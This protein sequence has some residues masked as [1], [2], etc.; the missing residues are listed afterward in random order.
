MKRMTFKEIFDEDVKFQNENGTKPLMSK[1]TFDAIR[2]NFAYFTEEEKSKCIAFY[3]EFDRRSS[4]EARENGTPNDHRYLK[5]L[6]GTLNSYGKG[7]MIK[8][9][10]E[11]GLDYFYDCIANM[12]DNEAVRDY[13]EKLGLTNE[14]LVK[15]V[16]R[17]RSVESFD[18]ISTNEM[19]RR[20]KIALAMGITEEDIRKNPIL[21][22]IDSEILNAR[23]N[24]YEQFSGQAISM[25]YEGIKFLT[26]PDPSF[27]RSWGEKVRESAKAHDIKKYKKFFK[28]GKEYSEKDRII[29]TYA[30]IQE[31]HRD[32]EKEKEKEVMERFFEEGIAADEL[33]EKWDNIL[34][35]GKKA[36]PTAKKDEITIGL[37]GTA[38]TD[39]KKDEF[40]HR[41]TERFGN[42][43]K[44]TGM[45]FSQQGK[46]KKV[47]KYLVIDVGAYTVLEPVGQPGNATY[48]IASEFK[49]FLP[50]LTRDGAKEMGVAFPINHE[51]NLG[52]YNWGS[53]KLFKIIDALE[54]HQSKEGKG[55]TREEHFKA[56][57]RAEAAGKIVRERF[58]DSH[59]L[60][61]AMKLGVLEQEKSTFKEIEMFVK[62]RVGSK[63]NNDGGEI[64]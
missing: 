43:A 29:R 16:Y 49:E 36:G 46:S 13:F 8:H 41:M 54:A 34:P 3:F 11:F 37:S 55:F 31:M 23:K 62:K 17:Y 59:L 44:F 18:G 52:R 22:A 5:Y 20:C 45:S 6:W 51:T 10:E 25:G 24:A 48:I 53:D 14:E 33:K 56:M 64:E 61:I 60:S 4:V 40:W 21:L 27:E 9:A 38:D 58:A 47:I 32:K 35:A 39:E 12:H 15:K 42:D 7:Y 50:E 63:K 19:E 30:L 28:D 2:E 26:M 57:E 1:V